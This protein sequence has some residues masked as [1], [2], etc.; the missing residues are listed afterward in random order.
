MIEER[1]YRPARTRAEAISELS[2]CAG[3]H[4]DPGVVQAL[5]AELSATP[6]AH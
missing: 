6:A 2:A 1:P 3:S 4:F 5:E